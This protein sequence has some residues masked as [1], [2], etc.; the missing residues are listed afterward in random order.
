MVN[1]FITGSNHHIMK[2]IAHFLKHKHTVYTYKSL[3]RK[4]EKYEI[5]NMDET[6]LNTMDIIIV[7][8]S[9]HLPTIEQFIQET[10]SIKHIFSMN[11]ISIHKD[12][13]LHTSIKLSNIIG[14]INSSYP[15]R[16]LNIKTS[17]AIINFSTSFLSPQMVTFDGKF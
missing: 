12:I 17:E 14:I 2:Y 13:Q 7:F 6:I 9:S 4:C 15:K 3:T 1:I 10:T 5:V 16:E 11:T 8:C